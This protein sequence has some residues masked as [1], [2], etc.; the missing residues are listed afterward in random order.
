MAIAFDN[1]LGTS[2]GGGPNTI[3]YT[4]S[5]SN[6]YLFYTVA[7]DHQ[8]G[9][10]ISTITYA[11]IGLTQLF[12]QNDGLNGKIEIWGLVAPATGANNIV[13]TWSAQSFTAAGIAAS[14]TGV[15]QVTPL[16]TA[17]GAAGFGT[18]MSA[19]GTLVA[20][21]WLIG[22]F[23]ES[24]LVPTITAGTERAQQQN[25]GTVHGA[26]ADSTAS[27]ITYSLSVNDDWASIG[28][29]LHAAG[30]APTDTFT[31]AWSM[32]SPQI[33]RGAPQMI[34]SGAGPNPRIV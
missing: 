3:S 12:S 24:N 30:A 27:P 19:T 1:V 26:F 33:L 13:I 16:G 10:T 28:V 34:A 31:A 8:A 6:R 25:S 32:Q 22:V 5:G 7:N 2:L 29:P 17:V 14:Y 11:G 4:V 20:N 18:V 21:D 9:Q 23:E 15:D